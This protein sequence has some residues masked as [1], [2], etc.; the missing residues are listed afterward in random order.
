VAERIPQD[1]VRIALLGDGASWLWSAMTKCFPSGRCV[2][3]HYHCLEH[4]YTVAKTQFE[5]PET[6]LEWVEAAL[7]WLSLDQPG[8]VIAWLQDM[9]PANA[10]AQEEIRKLVGYLDHNRER[11]G[12]AKCRQQGL[13][14]GS[15]GIESANKY[16][17]H[18]RL[19]RSG[20]WWLIPN[21]NNMLRLR[22]AIYN[23][24]YD[25]VLQRYIAN[26]QQRVSD[27]G[28]NG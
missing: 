20:A 5:A 15:G 26:R 25:R 12:Y 16:I 18:A 4:L 14:I 8:L 6:I 13:P 21:G 17:S 24:T 28:T 2:L 11:L 22:C 10:G 9:K 3:D 19:K 7:S 1:K 23:G 27:F